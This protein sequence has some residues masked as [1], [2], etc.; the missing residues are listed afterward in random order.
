MR[1]TKPAIVAALAFLMLTAGVASSA[2]AGHPSRELWTVEL[3]SV[4]GPRCVSVTKDDNQEGV[5]KISNICDKKMTIESVTCAPAI[6]EFDPVEIPSGA[7]KSLGPSS[8][9]LDGSSLQKGETINV[10]FSP[11][12]GGAEQPTMA[13]KFTYDGMSDA[14]HTIGDAG[15]DTGSDSDTGGPTG[16]TGGGD[17]NDVAVSSDAGSDAATGGGGSS[18][19]KSKSGGCSTTGGPGAPVFALLLM[20]AAF[21][22]RPQARG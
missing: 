4:A 18:D 20:T 9:G 3:N 17:N 16:D 22:V 6:C 11:K 15:G 8:F 5:F 14:S 21:A 7:K 13:F 10:E 1:R 19:S 2:T 12:L